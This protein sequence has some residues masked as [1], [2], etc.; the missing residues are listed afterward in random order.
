M[1]AQ[2]KIARTTTG[3]ITDLSKESNKANQAI[4]PMTPP[5]GTVQV[6][7]AKERDF[8]ADVM[9]QALRRAG[10]GAPTLVVQFFQ[11]G[12]NQG[13]EHPRHL[14]QNLDWLRCNLSRELNHDAELTEAETEAI[15]QLWQFTKDA[16]AL[17]K[18]QLLVL[19]ELN[20]AIARS[21]ISA[22][23]ILETLQ[24]RPSRTDVVLTGANMPASLLEYADQVTQRRN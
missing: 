16:I 9:A 1:V 24:H 15:L 8:Y 12:I 11:G 2:I 5:K 18:Y 21:L 13:V 10:L 14:G 22:E 19:D 4:I 7:T 6:F 3:K 17:N 20:L 23:E